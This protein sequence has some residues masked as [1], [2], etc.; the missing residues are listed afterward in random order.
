MF[1]NPND[2]IFLRTL[3]MISW[4]WWMRRWADSSCQCP[5]TIVTWHRPPVLP[6][7]DFITLAP[8]PRDE[9]MPDLILNLFLIGLKVNKPDYITLLFSGFSWLLNQ[10]VWLSGQKTNSVKWCNFWISV[11]WVYSGRARSC[12]VKGDGGIVWQNLIWIWIWSWRF[13]IQV[14]CVTPKS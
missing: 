11:K 6:A 2:A 3:K 5:V 9:E 1:S 12:L 4:D 8:H 13:Y 10:N 7:Q 14:L